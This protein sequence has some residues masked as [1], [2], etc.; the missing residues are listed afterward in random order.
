MSEK[1]SAGLLAVREEDTFTGTVTKKSKRDEETDLLA[2]SACLLT[3]HDGSTAAEPR[4]SIGFPGF[5]D[6]EAK[7][8]FESCF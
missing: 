8:V 4:D 7:N 6:S 5:R 2:I 3:T 1:Y